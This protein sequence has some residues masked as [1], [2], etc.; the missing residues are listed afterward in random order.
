MLSNTYHRFAG[1][2]LER[3][4]VLSDGIF[5]VA[6]TL[7]VL[8]LHV[9]SIEPPG[10]AGP[11]WAA[12]AWHAEHALWSALVGLAPRVLVYLLGFLTLGIFWIG[13]QTQLNHFERSD[14][15]LTWIHLAFLLVVAVMPFST[16][17]LAEYTALRVALLVY[18][19]HLLMLGALL[20]ASLRYAARAGLIRDGGPA[21]AGMRAAAERRIVVAQ[22]LYALAV[23]LGAVS[24]CLSVGLIIALQLNSALAPRVRPLDRY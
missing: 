23:V 9:P 18:W 10:G 16:S 19:L 22:A 6:M 2:N 4:A 21:T 12:G 5:A 20:L 13:R 11:L 7:L 8:D 17:L 14:R 3:L 1:S 15:R 24:T